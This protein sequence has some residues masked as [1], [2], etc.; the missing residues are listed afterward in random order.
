MSLY[1]KCRLQE[2]LDEQPH[3]LNARDVII[4]TAL[5]K[6]AAVSGGNLGEI[7]IEADVLTQEIAEILE[8]PVPEWYTRSFIEGVNACLRNRYLG[9]CAAGLGCVGGQAIESQLAALGIDQLKAGPHR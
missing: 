9:Y 2:A 1:A 6:Q 4:A 8:V 5:R 7:L 3:I